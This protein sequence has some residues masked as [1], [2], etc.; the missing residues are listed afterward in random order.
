ML[1]TPCVSLWCGITMGGG[2][3]IAYHSKYRIASDNTLCSLPETAL[4]FFPDVGATYFLPRLPGYVGMYL[5]LTGAQLRGREV[6]TVG[7][8]SHFVPGQD[9]ELFQDKLSSVGKSEEVES[10]VNKYRSLEKES[11]RIEEN[12]EKI[13]Y[14]FSCT[15][16][17]RMLDVLSELGDEWSQ[18]TKDRLLKMSPTSLKVTHR[19]LSLGGKLTLQDCLHM[20]SQLSVNFVKKRDLFV[21]IRGV[22][23]DKVSTRLDWD[24]ATLD[25]VSEELVM[26]HFVGNPRHIKFYQPSILKNKL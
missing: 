1:Q 13:N 5:G 7:L 6:V 20:E 22:L 8:A 10:L 26:S 11:N 2:V 24:P 4:G 14:V 12:L 21:G 19:A 25:D 18:K 15:S 16:V 23:V 9:L 17:E 3:G